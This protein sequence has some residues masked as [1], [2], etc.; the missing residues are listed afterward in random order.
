[1]LTK[2]EPQSGAIISAWMMP[3]RLW[4]TTAIAMVIVVTGFLMVPAPSVKGA[5][6][7]LDCLSCHPK[8]LESHEKLG[9]GNGACYICHSNTDMEALRLLDSTP[10][11]LTEHP[12]LCGQC[13]QKRYDAWKAETHGIPGPSKEKCASCHNPHQPQIVLANITMPHPASQPPPSQHSPVLLTLLGLS[14]L[15]AVAVGVALMRKG[16]QP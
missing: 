3:I 5:P 9:S 6:P 1:M 8:K 4:L 7:P 10:L 2:G 15:F 11:P 16:E 12:Q 14:I 13:H